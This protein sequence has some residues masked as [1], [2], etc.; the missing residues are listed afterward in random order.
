MTI[1]L[2]KEMLNKYFDKRIKKEELG[3]W[4]EKIY[5]TLVKGDY[6]IVE[7]LMIYH[8]IRTLSRCHI[9]PDN[10][11]EEY[12]CSEEEI[13]SIYKVLNGDIN[14]R[15]TFKTKL[16]MV[17]FENFCQRYNINKIYISKFYKMKNYII[18]CNNGQNLST[19]KI[20]EIMSLSINDNSETVTLVDLLEAHLAGI[21]QENINFDD[22]VFNYEKNVG[23]Y[24]V[25]NRNNKTEAISSLLRILNCITGDNEFRISVTYIKGTPNLCLLV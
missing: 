4:A 16:P 5:Y 2:L 6:I 12:P 25:R 13:I 21:L 11:K 15:L 14:K 19:E 22:D 3:I 20:N 1:D 24:A 23:I 9:I 18:Q 7:N 8:F 10:S 17:I